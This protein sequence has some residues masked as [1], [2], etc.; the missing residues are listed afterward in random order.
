[1]SLHDPY[2]MEALKIQVQILSA[3]QARDAIHATLHYQLAWRVQNYDRDLSLPGG[4]H[5]LFLDIDATNGT[6]HCAQI[7]RQITK[8]ELVKVLP[9]AWVT[10]YEKLRVHP[11]HLFF[12]EPNLTKPKNDILCHFPHKRPNQIVFPIH[13]HQSHINIPE[14]KDAHTISWF[15]SG[16]KCEHDWI[17]QFNQD[18]RG[19][20]WF[21]FPFT[22]HTPWNIECDCKG[23]Q[24]GDLDDADRSKSWKKCGNSKKEFKRRFDDGDPT[25]GSLSHPG[26]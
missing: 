5:S 10:K 2:L 16:F 19:V 25:I 6:T 15:L 4:Q 12:D 18:G 22:G 24:E 11:Q 9:D 21:S 20:Q 26:K 7:P 8:K 1:M 13:M 17:R 14:D 23:C 3:P